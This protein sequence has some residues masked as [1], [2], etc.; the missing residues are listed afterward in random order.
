[1]GTFSGKNLPTEILAGIGGVIAQ[2]SYLAFQ[3]TVILRLG[4]GLTK[5][6]QRALLVG[7]EV[8]VLCGQ[9]RTLASTDHWIKNEALRARID[10]LAADVRNASTARNDYAHGIFGYLIGKAGQ[11]DEEKFIR[12]VMKKGPDRVRPQVEEVTVES[13]RKH[14]DKAQALFD[15]AQAITDQLKGK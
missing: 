7:A 2:W 9:L 1:M 4:H 10:D 15:R 5:E 11:A 13:L 6:S 3:L 8:G 14:A 12:H